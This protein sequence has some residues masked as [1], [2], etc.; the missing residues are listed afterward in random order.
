MR[1]LEE[2]R[3]WRIPGLFYVNDMALCG[4]SEEEPKLMVE[5][6]VEKCKRGGLKVIADQ[7]DG[8]RWG[9][10]TGV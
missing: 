8:V 2:G 1:F 7:G 10:G 3:E 9:G 4:E 5:R 6:F